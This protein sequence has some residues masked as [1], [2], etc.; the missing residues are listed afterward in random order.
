MREDDIKRLEEQIEIEKTP[1]YREDLRNRV[2]RLDDI[3]EKLLEPIACFGPE[4][5]KHQRYINTLYSVHTIPWH[6]PEC[7]KYL[8]MREVRDLSH[9]ET[10]EYIHFS[11]NCGYEYGKIEIHREIPDGDH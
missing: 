8:N 1:K 7:S 3:A 6:C 10:V 4:H 2:K 5:T 9:E 11:C